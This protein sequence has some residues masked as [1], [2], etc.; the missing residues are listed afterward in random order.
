MIMREWDM[1]TDS[2]N[3]LFLFPDVTNVRYS[4]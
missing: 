4:C 2:L 1:H 3:R